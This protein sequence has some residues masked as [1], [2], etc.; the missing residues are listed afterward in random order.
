MSGNHVISEIHLDTIIKIF[1][2][3][4]SN[5]LEDWNLDTYQHSIPRDPTPLSGRGTKWQR[6]VALFKQNKVN[7]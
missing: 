7:H 3:L 5:F 6:C 2:W 1:L 4:Y